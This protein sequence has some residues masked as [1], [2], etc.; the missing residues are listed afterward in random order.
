MLK[1]IFHM[2]SGLIFIMRLTKQ[3]TPRKTPLIF[4]HIHISFTIDLDS[5]FSE[6]SDLLESLSS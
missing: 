4:H 3:V 1:I 2:I 5:L 6:E